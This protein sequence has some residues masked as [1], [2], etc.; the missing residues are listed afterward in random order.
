MG[1]GESILGCFR[2][3][4]IIMDTK[5]DSK[6]CPEK[7]GHPLHAPAS[8]RPATESDLHAINAIYN[9]Y[10]LNSTCTYQE[11]PD[12]LESRGEWLRGHGARYPV[13]VAECSHAIVGWGA[14][15]PYHARTAYRFTVE[16]S[17]YVHPDWL[18]RGIGALL[19]QHL[20]AQARDLGYHAIIAGIDAGQTGSLRLHARQGFQQ[21]G[22]LRQV[23][24]KCNRWLDVIYM[25]L[26]V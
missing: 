1:G 2:P 21:V 3:V 26:S 13:T 18:R 16:N 17:I 19:L 10:V 8:L 7:P 20:V 9:Y 4:R 25:E 11:L 23:G 12:T 5:S 6:S 24:F 15:S 22:R 14:L